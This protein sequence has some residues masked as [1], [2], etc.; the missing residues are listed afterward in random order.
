[1]LRNWIKLSLSSGIKL[2][3]STSDD[4]KFQSPEKLGV[5]VSE[6]SVVKFFTR[7]FVFSFILFSQSL[8]LCVLQQRDLDFFSFLFTLFLYRTVYDLLRPKKNCLK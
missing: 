4:Y 8:L 2:I 1:M 3:E 7:D 6:F 5:K